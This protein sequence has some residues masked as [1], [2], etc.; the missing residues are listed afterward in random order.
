MRLI[1]PNRKYIQS[2]MEVIKEDEV[3]KYKTY[4]PFESK[5]KRVNT[6]IK[7]GGKEQTLT[8]MIN[9]YR[10]HNNLNEEICN[11]SNLKN[12]I[13]NIKDKQGNTIESYF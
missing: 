3:I 10:E 7:N 11:F 2:Y 5:I 1:R 12:I 13:N 8:E 6:A 4:E 9:I